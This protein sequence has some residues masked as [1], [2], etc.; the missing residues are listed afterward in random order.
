MDSTECKFT[1][2]QTILQVAGRITK[3]WQRDI[4]VWAPD[5]TQFSR[6]QVNTALYHK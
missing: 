1:L 5:Q 4:Y 6:K 2:G 3:L